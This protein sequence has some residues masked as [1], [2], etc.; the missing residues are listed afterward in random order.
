MKHV[1]I[2]DADGTK[3]RVFPS[4]GSEVW[5]P[6]GVVC[7]HFVSVDIEPREGASAA[8][9]LTREEATSLRNALTRW[10]LQTDGDAAAQ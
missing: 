2:E 3:V 7:G 4:S 8:A 10:L 9:H 6:R 5:G 1:L